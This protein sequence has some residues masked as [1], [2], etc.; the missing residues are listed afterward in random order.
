MTLKVYTYSCK[1]HHHD[2]WPLVWERKARA[3]GISL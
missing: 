1:D 3:I 2:P